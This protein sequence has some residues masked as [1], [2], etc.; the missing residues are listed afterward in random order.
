MKYV[1]W[2][3]AVILVL[4]MSAF[5]FYKPI[6]V[7]IPEAFGV[8]CY[9]DDVCVEDPAQLDKAVA[10]AND[11]KRYLEMRWGLSVGQP[12]IVFCSTEKCR[13][14]FGHTR[15]AGYTLGT[16]GIVIQPRGWKEYYVAHEMIHY[17]QAENFGSLALLYGKPWV[18]EGMAYALSNDPR[19]KL[20][21]PFGSYRK[22]FGDWY[23]AHSGASLKSSVGKVL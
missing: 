16:L 5:A 7:T 1:K 23:R 22:Q 8:H 10:L 13:Q 14:T 9:K 12:K 6:R 2:F 17:W 19:K 15:T 11:S 21:E 4:P 20:Q 18:I 3:I